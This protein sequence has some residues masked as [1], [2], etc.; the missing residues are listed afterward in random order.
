MTRICQRYA[1]GMPKVH[2]RS[3]TIYNPIFDLLAMTRERLD[4]LDV[5]NPQRDHQTTY[6]TTY[7]PTLIVDQDWNESMLPCLDRA[8]LW[9]DGVGL[10]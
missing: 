6:Q 4:H 1:K 10:K 7:N 5:P 9:L 2:L 3:S 8:I